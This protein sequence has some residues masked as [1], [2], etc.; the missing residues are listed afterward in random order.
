M[1]LK[2]DNALDQLAFREFSN[3]KIVVTNA[4]LET[5]KIQCPRMYMP[6]GYRVFSLNTARQNTPWILH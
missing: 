2:I 3:K 6:F 4:A 5:F 1:A